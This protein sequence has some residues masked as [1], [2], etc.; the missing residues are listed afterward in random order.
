LGV[1]PAIAVRV[2]GAGQR[3]IQT[4]VPG[5][6]CASAKI[7]LPPN[8][9]FCYLERSKEMNALMP[10][11]EIHRPINPTPNKWEGF[12][13][14]DRAI[15]ENRLTAYRWKK[16]WADPLARIGMLAIIAIFVAYLAYVVWTDF[17]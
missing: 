7:L 13:E 8:C 10:D 11:F 3:G 2:E 16:A 17:L 15:A 9:K 6:W 14:V 4:I 5:H 1:L 12:A